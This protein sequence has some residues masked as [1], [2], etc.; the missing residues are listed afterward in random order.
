MSS[1]VFVEDTR[2]TRKTGT[3]IGFLRDYSEESQAEFGE[4]VGIS[5][6]AVSAI[7]KG[8]KLASPDLVQRIADRFGISY[9]KVC[10]VTPIRR[11]ELI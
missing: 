1:Y 8:R 7:E 3:I 5:Q 6:S 4:K 2:I 10:G 9:E 11:C